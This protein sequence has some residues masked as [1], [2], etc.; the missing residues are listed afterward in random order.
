MIRIL[1]DGY[2]LLHVFETTQATLELQREE[3][4]Q[5]LLV[6]KSAKPHSIHIVFDGAQEAMG[7]NRDKRG[8]LLIEFSRAPENAD[9]RIMTLCEKAKH[10]YLVI[11]GDQEIRRNVEASGHQCVSAVDFYKKMKSA[12][13]PRGGDSQMPEEED[14]DRPLY[15]KI[16]TQKKGQSRRPAKSKRLRNKQLK[17]L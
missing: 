9:R 3:L 13:Q 12:K 14:D 11:T 15:P 7:G 10:K 8:S 6:Y 2:N 4:L 5:A 1:I 16:S 17:K